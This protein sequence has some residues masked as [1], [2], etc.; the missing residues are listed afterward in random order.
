MLQ[1]VR[2]GFVRQPRAAG[3][4]LRAAGCHLREM[5]W[6]GQMLARACMA[7]LACRVRGM[8]WEG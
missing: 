4:P 3:Y 2:M 6:E 1:Y 8:Q 7:G 5:Q